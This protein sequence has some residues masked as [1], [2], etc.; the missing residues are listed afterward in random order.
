MQQSSMDKNIKRA[1]RFNYI[2][3]AIVAILVIALI[4]AVVA[5]IFRPAVYTITIP[6]IQSNMETQTIL[7]K[8]GD[9][10]YQAEPKDEFVE[11][12]SFDDW[13]QISTVPAGE[14]VLLLQLA[15]LYVIEFYADG[16]VAA[17][18]GYS[19]IGYKSYAYYAIPG[20]TVDQIINSLQE[21]GTIHQYGDGTI[22]SSTFNH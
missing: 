21:N 4:I 22:G 19:P 18:D 3:F 7:A 10:Y 13:E 6:G 16:Q 2:V 15:E 20:N 9:A 5:F 11:L 17:Y 8:V 1:K 14:P 12:F